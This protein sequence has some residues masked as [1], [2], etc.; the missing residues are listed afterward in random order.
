MKSTSS[1]K[2]TESHLRTDIFLS[3]AFAILVAVSRFLPHPPNFSPVLALIIFSGAA[4]TSRSYSLV[5]SLMV[6]AISDY[7]LGFY[8]GIEYVYAAYFLTAALSFFISRNK[9]GKKSAVAFVNAGL[10]SSLVFF[11]LSN[12]GVWLSTELY[13]K[14]G[15]GLFECFAMAIPFY[16]YTLT[17]TLLGLL[18][19][20]G[21]LKLTRMTLIKISSNSSESPVVLRSNS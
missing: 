4:F 15:M 5:I 11:V 3:L 14:T 9:A 10:A 1:K 12:L 19:L 7:F 20:F 13:P 18:V 17:S 2:N 21:L 6:I 8:P 16:V